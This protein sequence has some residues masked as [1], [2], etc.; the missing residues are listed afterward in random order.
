M[1]TTTKTKPAGTKSRAK[2]ASPTKFALIIGMLR[3]PEGATIQQ[4][5]ELTGWK[6]HSV[7]GVLAGAL[8]TKF[9]LTI[10]SEKPDKVRIYRATSEPSP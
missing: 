2:T 10:V 6:V 1:T 5:T 7:R 8:K 9:G 4:L 3:R